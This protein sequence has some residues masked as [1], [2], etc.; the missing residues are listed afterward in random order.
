[1]ASHDDSCSVKLQIDADQTSDYPPERSRTSLWRK[2]WGKLCPGQNSF[3]RLRHEI[4]MLM[5][6][7]AGMFLAFGIEASHHMA[8][9]GPVQA[10]AHKFF[11]VAFIMWILLWV[12]MPEQRKG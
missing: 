12:F 4:G 9:I 3:H 7:M 1:M 10:T 6:V 2:L 8:S 5:G 11:T